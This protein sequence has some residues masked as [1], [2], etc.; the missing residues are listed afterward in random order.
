MFFFF[1]A[2]KEMRCLTVAWWKKTQHSVLVATASSDGIETSDPTRMN[3]L[4][5]VPIAKTLGRG[6]MGTRCWSDRLIE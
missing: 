3:R 2:M 1:L 6:G 4:R 5:A